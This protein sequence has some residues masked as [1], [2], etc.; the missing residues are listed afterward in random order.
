[1]TFII[2]FTKIFLKILTCKNYLRT[3]QNKR[4]KLISYLNKKCTLPLTCNVEEEIEVWSSAEDSLVTWSSAPWRISVGAVKFFAWK[5]IKN[6][7][8]NNSKMS[9][10]KYFWSY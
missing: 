3:S 8:K 9:Q 4:K 1:M 6:K 5:F 10:V 2:Y 7:E